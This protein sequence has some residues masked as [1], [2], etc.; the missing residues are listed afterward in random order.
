MTIDPAQVDPTL[1]SALDS[2]VGRATETAEVTALLRTA[3]LFTLTGTGGS[4]KTRLARHLVG[5]VG[6]TFRHGVRW[7][8]LST[9]ADGE[10][11]PH[12]VAA[13]C[14][15]T[16]LHSPAVLDALVATL[17]TQHLLLVLDNCEHVLPA[18]ASLLTTLLGACAELHILATSREALALPGEVSWLVS[19]LPVPD[20]DRLAVD[21]ALHYDA[22][23]LFVARA[24]AVLPAFRLSAENGPT[25]VRICRLLE[26]LPLALELAAARLRVVS[27]TDL[28][29]RLTDALALLTGGSRAAPPRQHS[30]RATLD[31]SYGLLSDE[32]RA[33]FGRLA[34]FAGSFSLA[35]A[36]T[37]AA[38]PGG[39]PA[40]TLD[41]VL[42]LVEKSLVIVQERA[43]ETRYR[44]LEPI[45][46]YALDRLRATGLEFET[47]R[48][49]RDWYAAIAMQMGAARPGTEHGRWFDRLARDHDNIRAA[50]A[51]SLDHGDAAG[52]GQIAAGV[53]Q[54]WHLHGRL[55]E[56]R[57]WLEQILIALPE[58]T[59]LRAQLLWVAGILARPDAQAAHARFSESLGLWQALDDHD[60][61]ARVLG[62]LGFLAQARGD[63]EQAVTYLEQSL[64]ILRAGS[65]TSA[66]ARILSGLALSL[67]ARGE[68]ERATSVGAESLAVHQQAGDVRGV[69][70]A[71]TNLGSIW[72]ARGDEPQAEALWEASLR[73]RRRIGDAGGV[74]HVLTLLGG[75]AVDQRA[76]GTAADRYHEALAVRLA[77]GDDDSVAPILEGL[78]AVGAMQQGEL[79]AVQL[80]GAADALRGAT[81]EAR[82]ASEQAAVERTL[83]ALRAQFDADAFAQAWAAGRA[84]SV[85]QAIAIASALRLPDGTASG[86]LSGA[87]DE[88][89]THGPPG[90]HTFDLTPRERE[91]LRLLA[92]GLTYA[93]IGER[94]VIS[95]RTVDAH[96]RAIFG[97]LGVRS[98][99]AA[100]HI[101]LQHRLI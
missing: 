81:G 101:A 35:A 58:R 50:L 61:T 63:H 12:A 53:W 99:S 64:P 31:W 71:M 45:R 94:L 33:V 43:E 55:H 54:F 62:S 16:D 95:P 87:G 60:G 7:V 90:A 44:L 93:Q 19:P 2:F 82:S 6:D 77:M 66:R 38:G 26:G 67:L 80:A 30:L 76:Y 88:P 92:E 68:L 37:V 3:R 56:G 100:T 39:T 46:Q 25:I 13:R 34:C 18:C 27:P 4:G 48:R 29:A 69:A 85:Q 10:L 86:D 96:A 8:D 72:Q 32:E 11:V 73:D 57:R 59:P 78:A 51:W 28:A 47:R 84:L 70:A 41:A 97:K 65:D 1:P 15:V 36:E 23:A 17:R 49:H 74:A 42:Q 9:V 21:D 89:V 52:A 91:V 5:V 22:V 75:L 40:E 83:G 14:S 79:A 20:H 98:R 24:S